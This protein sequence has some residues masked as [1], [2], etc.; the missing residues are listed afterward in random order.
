MSDRKRHGK[1]RHDPAPDPSTPRAGG[2]PASGA[3]AAVPL[4]RLFT[5]KNRKLTITFMV[6]L[7][8]LD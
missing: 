5:T 1:K 3:G 7:M 8:W 4:S 6:R 2:D